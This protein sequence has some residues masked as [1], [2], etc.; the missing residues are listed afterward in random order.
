MLTDPLFRIGLEIRIKW[1]LSSL[2]L[3]YFGLDLGLN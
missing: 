3:C 1:Y 2:C